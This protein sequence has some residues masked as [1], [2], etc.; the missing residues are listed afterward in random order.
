MSHAWHDVPVYCDEG[1]TSF[2]V[3]V[4]VTKGSKV[5]YELDKP[6]GILRVDRI[7]YSSVVY[8]ANYGFIPQTYCDD[9]DPL[10]ALV[11]NTEPVEPLSIVRARAIGVMRMEDS[12]KMDDKLIVVHV[13]DP[14]V[15][16]YTDMKELPP[17]LARQIR[18]FFEEYK[19]LEHKK[20]IVEEFLGPDV[21][22]KILRDAV[23][24]YRREAGKL[25]PR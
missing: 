16:H 25:R 10:D 22:A 14:E 3:I 11:L 5:K 4:E 19:V 9:N 12:G 24:L 6:T 7:L 21:A 13:D 1:Q 2:H 23:D 15:A 20:V 8:P 18:H 17:H